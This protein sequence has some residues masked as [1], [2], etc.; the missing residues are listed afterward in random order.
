MTRPLISVVIPSYNCEKYVAEAIR[1]VFKQTY[2]PL[3]LVIV[4]DGSTDRS[5]E[6][7][8]PVLNAPPIE[9]VVYV[10]QENRGAHAAIMRGIEITRG[11]LLS[12][13]N[14]DD[15]YANER[16][17]TLSLRLRGDCELAFSGLDFVDAQSRRLPRDSGWPQWYATALR[18][19]EDCPA[20]GYALL[21]HNFSVTSGNFVFTRSLYDKLGGFSEHKFTHDWDFLMR[22]IYYTEPA[23]VPE[24]LMSYRIHETNT[25]ESVRHLL[26]N[27]ASDV[28]RRY[29]ALCNEGAPPNTLAPCPAHWPGYFPAFVD[30]HSPGFALDRRLA[31]FF[32]FSPG[33]CEPD[34]IEA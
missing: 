9:N 14:S 19:T 7:I 27:E 6:V 32:D 8:L 34:E 25:T 21:L 31:T 5:R 3:E 10:E 28:I 15:F 12:I 30:S 13:L 24:A 1:S 11:G 33:Q 20:L 17:A 4:D 2:R 16:L 29:S 26:V 23:F 22:S 18:E